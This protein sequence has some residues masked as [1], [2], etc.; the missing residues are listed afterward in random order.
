VLCIL[1]ELFLPRGH[2]TYHPPYNHRYYYLRTVNIIIIF[3]HIEMQF[4]FVPR[5]STRSKFIKRCPWLIDWM[6]DWLTDWLTDWRTDW[7]PEWVNEW[8]SMFGFQFG[9]DQAG[10]WVNIYPAFGN[11]RSFLGPGLNGLTSRLNS[12]IC[13]VLCIHYNYYKQPNIPWFSK[14]IFGI[15]HKMYI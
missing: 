5:F 1:E 15:L 2:Y 14:I 12:T 6:T 4:R 11:R 8:I 13:R 9:F 7:M 3:T 10:L